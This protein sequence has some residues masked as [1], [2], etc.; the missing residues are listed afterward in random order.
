MTP[1]TDTILELRDTPSTMLCS[2]F[3]ILFVELCLQTSHRLPPPLLFRYYGTMQGLVFLL[4][5][6]SLLNECLLR[7]VL[8]LFMHVV[9][10]TLLVGR[11]HERQQLVFQRF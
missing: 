8:L 4:D 11:F 6:A 5:L 7:Y 9:R 1:A 10:L 3:L 2:N